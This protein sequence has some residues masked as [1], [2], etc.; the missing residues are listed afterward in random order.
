[1]GAPT[2]IVCVSVLSATDAP[3]ASSV[4][5]VSC[6]TLVAPCSHR[7][8][9]ATKTSTEPGGLVTL[10]IVRDATAVVPFTS[11]ANDPRSPEFVGWFGSKSLNFATWMNG[12]IRSG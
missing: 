2:A 6:A 3:N 10:G 9:L 4:G 12:S 11:I 8:F 7:P 5:S 1:M